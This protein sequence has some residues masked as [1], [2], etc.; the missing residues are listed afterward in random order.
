MLICLTYLL[1]IAQTVIFTQ[2][3]W[4]WYVSGYGNI[5]L[6]DNVGTTWIS[7]TLFGGI[8]MFIYSENA[9]VID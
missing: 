8:G 4:G 9:S 6:F 7:V 5:Q 2:T 3:L 1:E